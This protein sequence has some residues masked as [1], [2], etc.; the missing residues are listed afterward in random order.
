MAVRI[1][2]YVHLGGGASQK[3]GAF[4][5]D[6]FALLLPSPPLLPAAIPM[7]IPLALFR[8]RAPGPLPGQMHFILVVHVVDY[9]QLQEAVE[10]K[11]LRNYIPLYHLCLINFLG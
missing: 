10:A 1:L 3:F 8:R 7:I 11:A 9:H 6:G 4:G 2:P 5:G